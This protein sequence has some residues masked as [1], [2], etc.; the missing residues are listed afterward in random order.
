MLF[1]PELSYGTLEL[2]MYCAWKMYLCIVLSF[3]QIRKWVYGFQRNCIE[4][5]FQSKEIRYHALHKIST[6]WWF[7]FT[8]TTF[9]RDILFS[10]WYSVLRFDKFFKRKVKFVW[11]V[12][13]SN[14]CMSFEFISNIEKCVCYCQ[15]P[16][17]VLVLHLV[18]TPLFGVYRV[19]SYRLCNKNWKSK[20]CDEIVD[21]NG[22]NIQ[23]LLQPFYC[24]I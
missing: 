3:Q 16:I 20:K 14:Q 8:F 10:E 2:S 24:T 9:H 17:P 22:N 15:L 19:Y 1:F 5:P 12:K 21:S 7:T 13:P 11:T 18:S 6:Q 4:I 23:W